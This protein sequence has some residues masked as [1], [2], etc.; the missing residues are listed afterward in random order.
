MP[1]H[2]H[3]S[4]YMHAWVLSCFRCVQLFGTL[5][6][7]AR[8]APLSVGFSRQ[9]YWSG[10]TLYTTSCKHCKYSFSESSSSFSHDYYYSHHLSN[11]DYA[12]SWVLCQALCMH[13]K[14][15]QSSWILCGPMN[16]SLPGSSV[17]G[18]FQ[19]SILEWVA[20][21]S[22]RASS[23]PASPVAP[24]LQA[25]SLPSE[26]QAKTSSISLLFCTTGVVILILP[27]GNWHP[28]TSHGSPSSQG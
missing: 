11:I 24:A 23:W 18:I 28:E 10:L 5:W 12:V 16:C 1:Y 14:S 15:L 22:S 27:W 4:L 19:A 25:D 17:H 21:P 3:P 2:F 8:Q 26:P 7:V 6:T 9:E 20:I 13:S